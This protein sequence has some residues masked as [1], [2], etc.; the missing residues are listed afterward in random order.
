M[1]ILVNHVPNM[2]DVMSCVGFVGMNRFSV[3]SAPR[4]AYVRVALGGRWYHWFDF[5]WFVSGAWYTIFSDGAWR[6][7][8]K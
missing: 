3:W 7:V 8:H 4:L 2:A 1:H 5:A 6:S